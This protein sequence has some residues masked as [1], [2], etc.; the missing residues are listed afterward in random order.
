MVDHKRNHT[1]QVSW[2]QRFKSVDGKFYYFNSNTPNKAVEHRNPNKVF[3]YKDLY[4]YVDKDDNR[5][6]DLEAVKYRDMESDIK[7]VFDKVTHQVSIG[8]CIRLNDAAIKLI[9]LFFVKQLERAIEFLDDIDED[10][11]AEM[12]FDEIELLRGVDARKNAEVNKVR[13]LQESKCKML[14]SSTSFD[15]FEDAIKDL[16]L[17]ILMPSANSSQFIIGSNP[18]GFIKLVHEDLGVASTHFRLPIS[19]SIVLATCNYRN[20]IPIFKIGA[21]DVENIN[22]AIVNE[23]NEIAGASKV[24]VEKYAEEMKA[25]VKLQK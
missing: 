19:P 1:V 2:F 8:K 23:S 17:C 3:R 22:L 18:S 21:S 4:I 24:L 20:Y 9:K 11:I 12:A 13:L 25:R 5:I 16:G 7:D 10:S 15:Y 6:T 14:G